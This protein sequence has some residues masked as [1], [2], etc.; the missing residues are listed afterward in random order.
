MNNMASAFDMPLDRLS[1]IGES[2]AKLYNKLGVRSVG[3][4][5]RLYPRTYEDWS[6]PLKISELP[7]NTAVCIK[8]VIEKAYKPARVHGNLIIYKFIASDGYDNITITF[9]NQK[10]TYEKLLKGGEFLF[11]GTVKKYYSNYEMSSPSVS[12]INSIGIHPVYPQTAGLTTKRIENAVRRAIGLLPVKMNDPIPKSIL[13]QYGLCSLDFAIRKIHFPDSTEDIEKARKRLAFE[14]L[15]VLQLG[16]ARLKRVGGREQPSYIIKEDYSGEFKRLLPFTLTGAQERAIGQCIAD[17][18]QHGHSMNRL[19]QGDVGSGKTAVAASVCYTAI[20]NGMQC[21]FM[22]PTEILAVQHYKSLCELL[23]D[24]GIR[25]ELLTGSVTLSKKRAIYGALEN[26]E[27]D[28]IIGTHAL[29]S[30][31]V[32]FRSLGLVITDEQHRF[33]VR[34]RAALISKGTN[35]HIMV[36]SA[37]PIPRTLALM[38]FGDLDISVLNE[39]PPGRQKVDTYLIDSGK[40]NRAYNFLKKHIDNGNRC[41]IVCPLVEEGET[42]LES[43]ENYV[44]KLKKTVLGTYGAGLLHG[45]MKSSD[46]DAVMAD[47]AAG[48]IDILVSTTVIEV[49]VNV[50]E[51]TVMMIEN[52]DRFGLSQLHQLRGRVGRGNNKSFCILVS[53]NQSSLTRKRLAVICQTNDGFKIADEDLRIRGPGDFFGSRQHGLPELKAAS[54]VGADMLEKTQ[55]AARN[56]IR[57]DPDLQNSEHRGLKAETDR[58]FSKVGN[59][60]QLQ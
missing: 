60:D 33:G 30:E 45:K 6:K 26:G 1:G 55:N 51:A 20:K 57:S 27:I 8:A 52:A 12:D 32:V 49:G 22:A 48:N 37:T 7:E 4:L 40:R 36:M 25:I 44:K 41:Y 11:Y 19:I 10:Y 59:T 54:T 42:E 23:S 9:F 47:F 15:L 43:A 31:N 50:P 58:L 53:D 39:L 21:A 29:I 17:M 16:M 3:E 38:I 35:P 13:E 14:E 5:L 46:K 56:I 34:Q 24:S 28:L 18:K 2:S